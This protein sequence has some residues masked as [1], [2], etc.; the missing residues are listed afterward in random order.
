MLNLLDLEAVILTGDLTYRP[1]LLLD[2]V[3]SCVQQS[4]M[5]RQAHDVK[6]EAA[7]PRPDAGSGQRAMVAIR[8]FLA[9]PGRLAV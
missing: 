2:R 9:R 7:L 8:R 3:R 4:R 6:I 5:A 1:D